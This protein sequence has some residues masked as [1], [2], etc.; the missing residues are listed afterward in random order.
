[1]LHQVFRHPEECSVAVPPWV[2][3]QARVVSTMRFP[4][5][6]AF[7]R[8]QVSSPIFPARVRHQKNAL[9]RGISPGVLAARCSLGARPAWASELPRPHAVQASALGDDQKA[10]TRI[11]ASFQA[12]QRPPTYLTLRATELP[13]ACWMFL[14]LRP[15]PPASDSRRERSRRWLSGPSAFSRRRASAPWAPV[16]ADRRRAFQQAAQLRRESFPA[17]V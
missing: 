14:I 17:R 2:F 12:A 9:P 3:D 5:R 13:R 11:P 1:M 15:L 16:A 6:R 10:V 4:A 7:P 8:R